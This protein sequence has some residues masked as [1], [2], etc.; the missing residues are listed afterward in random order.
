MLSSRH[1]DNRWNAAYHSHALSHDPVDRKIDWSNMDHEL[2]RIPYAMEEKGA[3]KL[4]NGNMRF[5]F[6]APEAYSVWIEGLCGTRY[7]MSPRGDGYWSADVA[8]LPAGFHYHHYSVN[9]IDTINILAPIGFGGFRPINYVEV[10][11]PEQHFYLLRNVPHGTIRMELYDSA[12]TGRT[13]NCWVYT[14]PGYDERQ[15]K[16]YPVLYLQ[17]GG[18]ENE[19]GW[20]WQGKIH[21][22]MDNMLADGLCSEMIVVMN[23]GYAFREEE[24]SDF[25]PGDFDSVLMKDCLPFIDSKYRTLTDRDS[26]AMAGLSMGAFQTLQTTFKH[27]DRFAW[28]GLFS[29]SLDYKEKAGFDHRLRFEDADAFN[30]QTRLLFVS[31]GEQEAGFTPITSQIANLRE[32]GIHC[33]FYSCQGYHDWTVWRKSVYQFLLRLFQPEHENE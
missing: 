16:R 14:P 2:R 21:Y 33:E 27:Q 28:I 15:D 30:R 8:G 4:D 7:E 23:N 20:I 19:T 31:M 24:L 1:D 22:I 12:V 17:H 11:D 3:V 32:Q 18:G 5:H 13:R 6:Y 29:G 10:P 9:G 26:R 25:L